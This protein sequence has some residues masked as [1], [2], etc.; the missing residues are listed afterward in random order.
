MP[1]AIV[2]VILGVL[3]SLIP[4]VPNIDLSPN[5]VLLAV[6]AA[7]GLQRGVLHRAQGDQGE[8]GAD[9]RAGYR[10]DGGDH[11]R[12][13]GV[14]RLILPDLGWAPALAFA[15]AVAPTDA[16]AATSVLTRLGA[17]QRI[18][19][20]LEGESLINDAVALTAFGLAVEAMA[21][22][23]T[24]GTACVRLVEVVVGGIAYGLVLARGDR[25]GPALRHAIPRSR[26]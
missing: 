11:R 21:H 2:L 24:F 3:A 4:Q 17:P 23:F 9:H 16:V 6:P 8:R 19:T 20:I 26:S 7:A 13:A 18:V 1:E 25:A 22:P 12:V 15:A 5:L 10:R 14:T